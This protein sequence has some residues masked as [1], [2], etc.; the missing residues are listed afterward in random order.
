MAE[1]QPGKGE[2]SDEEDGKDQKIS[3]THIGYDND[4]EFTGKDF[5]GGYDRRRCV[6]QQCGD[7]D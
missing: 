4:S 3:G 6:R 1:W 2:L 5:D 7:A